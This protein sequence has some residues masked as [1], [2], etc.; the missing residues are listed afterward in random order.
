MFYERVKL[1]EIDMALLT[2]GG[3]G[4]PCIYKQALL[5]EGNPNLPRLGIHQNSIDRFGFATRWLSG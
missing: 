2:E 5:T 4:S 1:S 3:L